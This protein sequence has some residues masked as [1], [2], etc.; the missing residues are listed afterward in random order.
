MIP[1]GENVVYDLGE[2]PLYKSLEINGRLG[3]LPGQDHKL[4]T[5]SVWVRAGMLEIGTE[6]E[7]FDGTVEIML[8]GNNTSP[9]EFVF[10]P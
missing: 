3:F 10:A 1:P 8:H 2:S 4:N 9:S 6:D 7:P 5:R